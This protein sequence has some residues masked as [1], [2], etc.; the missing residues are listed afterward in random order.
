MEAIFFVLVLLLLIG[1]LAHR[2]GTDSRVNDERGWW[3]GTH[4]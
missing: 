4:R 1:P 3:P 2:F